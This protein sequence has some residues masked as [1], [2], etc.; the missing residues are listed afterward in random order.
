MA[1]EYRFIKMVRMNETKC[2]ANDLSKVTMYDVINRKTNATIGL[3]S[4]HN[5]WK[6]YCL[7]PEEETVWSA[8]CLADVQHFIKSLED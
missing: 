2:E 4:W 5:W 3:I 6:Q 7:Y 8:D 1:K